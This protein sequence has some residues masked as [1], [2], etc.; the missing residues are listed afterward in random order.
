MVR[1][2]RLLHVVGTGPDISWPGGPNIFVISLITTIRKLRPLMLCLI[3]MCCSCRNRY[4]D[5]FTG[6]SYIAG[7]FLPSLLPAANISSN[8]RGP[9]WSPYLLQHTLSRTFLI[10]SCGGMAERSPQQEDAAELSAVPVQSKMCRNTLSATWEFISCEATAS[11]ADMWYVWCHQS[12]G[13]S[14]SSPSSWTNV[15]AVRNT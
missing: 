7:Q 3:S 9:S 10:C 11:V 4:L 12:G 1:C 6:I 13:M 14:R 15:V 8:T 5:M 2:R